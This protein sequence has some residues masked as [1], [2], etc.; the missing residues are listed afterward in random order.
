M[1]TL[2]AALLPSPASR[3]DLMD[4]LSDVRTVVDGAVEALFEAALD[5][6]H[7]SVDVT[8]AEWRVRWDSIKRAWQHSTALLVAC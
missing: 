2:G 4:P 7:G 5:R 3:D 6:P 8:A 1:F